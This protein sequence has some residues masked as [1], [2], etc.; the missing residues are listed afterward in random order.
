[1]TTFLTI[2]SVACY[3]IGGIQLL[4]AMSLEPHYVFQQQ[5]QNQ[6]LLLAVVLLALGVAFT[7][8]AWACDRLVPKP[9]QPARQY[10]PQLSPFD[11]K[12]WQSGVTRRLERESTLARWGALAALVLALVAAPVVG[13]LGSFGA[14]VATKPSAAPQSGR[15]SADI[16]EQAV[17]HPVPAPRI[18]DPKT[19]KVSYISRSR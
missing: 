8:A 15:L 16:R 9:P 7:V 5:V 4:D 12:A 6:K 14:M 11:A 2:V 13:A 18:I 10:E 19:P 17:P 1:M 3:V